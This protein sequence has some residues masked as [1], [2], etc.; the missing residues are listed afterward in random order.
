MLDRVPGDRFRAIAALYCRRTGRSVWAVAAAIRTRAVRRGITYDQNSVRRLVYGIVRTVPPELEQM[1]EA[2]YRKR[3]GG[4]GAALDRELRRRGFAIPSRPPLRYVPY[5]RIRPLVDLWRHLSPRPSYYALAGRILTAY[6]TSGRSRSWYGAWGM[7][8]GKQPRV[9]A[10]LVDMLLAELARFGIRSEAAARARCAATAAARRAAATLRA[11]ESSVRFFALAERWR[12]VSRNPSPHHLA[13]ALKARGIGMTVGALSVLL[14]SPRPHVQHALTIAMEALLRKIGV[15]PDGMPGP[16]E[17]RAAVKRRADYAWV[18]TAPLVA[19]ARA[20]VTQ[21]PAVT[22]FALAR[23]IAERLC[24]KGHRTRVGTIDPLLRGRQRVTRAFVY[25]ATM[26]ECTGAPVGEV[27]PEHHIRAPNILAAADRFLADARAHFERS[28]DRTAARFNAV[29]AE[30]RFGIPRDGAEA[31]IRNVPSSKVRPA[32]RRPSAKPT[33]RRP[34]PPPKP[35]RVPEGLEEDL[36]TL[37]VRDLE[38]DDR[39]LV[40]RLTA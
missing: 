28:G 21:H 35:P 3:F 30:R 33:L 13:H 37:A 1:A 24:R 14:Y 38:A 18:R 16:V 10:E 4:H 27:P 39:A 20:Y 26:V 25:R 34:V 8:N 15:D 6:A 19:A 29:R 32:Q 9:P 36:A 22:R 17:A 11:M 31:L 7:L 40:D 2:M 23:R 5:D 12:A